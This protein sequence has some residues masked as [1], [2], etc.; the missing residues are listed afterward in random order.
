MKVV[1]FLPV[2]FVIAL[3]CAPIQQFAETNICECKVAEAPPEPDCDPPDTEIAAAL[4]DHQLDQAQRRAESD[5]EQ[6]AA[7]LED[8]GQQEDDDPYYD[9]EQFAEQPVNP[10]VPESTVQFDD[11]EQREQF[12]EDH[13]IELGEHAEVFRTRFHADDTTAIVVHNPGEALEVYENG[14][15]VASVQLDDYEPKSAP[16]DLIE[17]PTGAVELVQDETEQLKVIHTESDED[18]RLTYHLVVYKFIGSR[19]GTIFSEPIAT[20]QQDE[21]V[22]RLADIRFLHGLDDRRIEW[23]PLDEEGNPADETRQYHWNRWE[24]V[25]RIPEPP[26]TA[27]EDTR[28]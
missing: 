17:Y 12:E 2:V 19:I 13:D 16:P 7:E 10:T 24:G 26:P 25:Y 18:G 3:G 8:A 20:R 11:T 15:V 6:F 14:Q 9:P 22:Q 28:S 1:T 23:I 27:P 5:G 21:S 4:V